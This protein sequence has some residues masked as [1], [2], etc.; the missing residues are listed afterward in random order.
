M[1]FGY[2]HTVM[3]LVTS[4]DKDSTHSRLAFVDM[5]DQVPQDHLIR[6]IKIIA[7]EALERPF[8][9]GDC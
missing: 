5:E 3:G 7:K 9:R 4:W 6:T 1:E 8:R 2:V